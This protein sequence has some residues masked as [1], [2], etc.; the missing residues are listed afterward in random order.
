[1]ATFEITPKLILHLP[2][3]NL[4]SVGERL[5]RR[6]PLTKQRGEFGEMR[7]V[8][9]LTQHEVVRQQPGLGVENALTLTLVILRRIMRDSEKFGEREQGFLGKHSEIMFE[10]C[11]N[12]DAAIG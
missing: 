1:M 12:L 2:Q 10:R 9:G 5:F 4:E 8:G 11:A 7:F 6:L 3:G